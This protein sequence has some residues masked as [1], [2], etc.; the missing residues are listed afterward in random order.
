MQ[1]KLLSANCFL[2]SLV[3]KCSSWPAPCVHLCAWVPCFDQ[4]EQ[5]ELQGFAGLSPPRHSKPARDA[6]TTG[7]DRR[8]PSRG[9]SAC[10]L[11]VGFG[12]PASALHLYTQ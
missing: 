9:V 5:E 12:A 11:E 7:V 6:D 3:R 2:F 8:K 1:L 4:K 10:Q